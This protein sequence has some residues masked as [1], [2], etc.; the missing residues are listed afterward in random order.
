MLKDE[1][2]EYFELMNGRKPNPKEFKEAL[3]RK[4]FILFDEGASKSDKTQAKTTEVASEAA[5]AGEVTATAR[6][7]AQAQ[8]EK[9]SDQETESVSRETGGL[10]QELETSVKTLQ[11]GRQVE[12]IQK[13]EQQRQQMEET[14]ARLASYA[15]T[16]PDGGR[17]E[18]SASIP[19]FSNKDQDERQSKEV[20]KIDKKRAKEQKKADILAAKAKAKEEKQMARL[21]KRLMRQLDVLQKVQG[22]KQPSERKKGWGKGVFISS[23]LALVLMLVIGGAYGF[24][25]N[26]SGDIK[27]IWEL[28]SSQVMDKESGKLTDALAEYQERDEV[29]ESYLEINDQNQVMSHSY[30]YPKDDKGQPTFTASDYLKSHQM[31]DQWNKSITYTMEESD[32]EKDLSDVVADLYPNADKKLVDYYIADNVDNYKLYRKGE[33]TKT[34]T[35]DNKELVISTYNEDGKLTSRDTYRKA[36][37][38]ESRKLTKDYEEARAAYEKKRKEAHQE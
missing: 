6:A 16:R 29:Y 33:R 19:V 38:S 21:E 34:Y 36:S 5:G 15:P 24:W 10:S 13:E 32:F 7:M 35:I 1:W 11:S 30:F 28:K 31:V 18:V 4:E 37:P 17:P 23:I 3:D 12:A 14:K 22:F 27:G 25:R 20:D 26:A 9:A 8:R 2:L